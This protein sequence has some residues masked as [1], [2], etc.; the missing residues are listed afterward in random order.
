MKEEED[1]N[2]RNYDLKDLLFLFKLP[3]HYTK[4]DLFAVKKLLA[5]NHPDKSSSLSVERF[6]FLKEAYDIL[7]NLL[8]KPRGHQEEIGDN[9]EVLDNFF[10]EEK[11]DNFHVWFNKHFEEIKGEDTSNGYEDWLRGKEQKQNKKQT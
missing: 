3:T 10:R 11:I 6:H 5:K 8:E 2:I 7:N 1:L 9:K 4:D